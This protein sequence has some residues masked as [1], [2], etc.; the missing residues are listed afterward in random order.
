[1]QP[2]VPAPGPADEV[3]PSPT[4]ALDAEGRAIDW[5]PTWLDISRVRR[6][7]AATDE[8][9]ES[10]RI[11]RHPTVHALAAAARSPYQARGNAHCWRNVCLINQVEGGTEFLVVREDLP[12]ESFSTRLSSE[13]G[14]VADLVS[15]YY[16]SQEECRAWDYRGR[17]APERDLTHTTADDV[18]TARWDALLRAFRSG[19][20]CRIHE[21][22]YWHI[23]GAP[24]HDDPGRRCFADVLHAGATVTLQQDPDGFRARRLTARHPR[25]RD[26]AEAVA[27]VDG[28][29]LP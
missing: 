25:M 17:D 29:G 7:S 8:P 12:F 24:A 28:P 14:L 23:L 6:L 20:C 10:R 4:E 13:V 1:M 16:S 9:L 19:A 18:G 22:V 15:I 3:P 26:G 27:P 2:P 21:S 11:C 5:I